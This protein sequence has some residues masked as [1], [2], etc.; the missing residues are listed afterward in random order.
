MSLTIRNFKVLN[1]ITGEIPKNG[2]FSQSL[3]D[4]ILSYSTYI[5]NTFEGIEVPGTPINIL[6]GGLK[7]NAHMS[8]IFIKI[9]KKLT[10]TGDKN[11]IYIPDG[12]LRLGFLKGICFFR[13]C[14]LY[15]FSNSLTTSLDDITFNVAFASTKSQTFGDYI[16]ISLPNT[17][18]FPEMYIVLVFL[19]NVWDKRTIINGN[20]CSISS[21]DSKYIYCINPTLST[22]D[23]SLSHSIVVQGL[24]TNQNIKSHIVVGFEDNKFSNS[25]RDYNDATFSICSRYISDLL[26]NDTVLSG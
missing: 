10:I 16:D 5:D 26:T 25:D 3:I 12:I 1:T 7:D 15:G 21:S 18:D 20:T 13:N 22:T 4:L 2:R 14:L 8:T 11:S 6:A 24:N 9:V 19:V 23:T 17:S